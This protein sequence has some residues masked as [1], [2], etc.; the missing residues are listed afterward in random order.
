MPDYFEQYYDWIDWDVYKGL[1]LR[2]QH[3][4]QAKHKEKYGLN[5]ILKP[6]APLEAVMAWREDARRTREADEEGKII[7]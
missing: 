5:H 4:L 6:G 3:E 1:S 2:E 7:N